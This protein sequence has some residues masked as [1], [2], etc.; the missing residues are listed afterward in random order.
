MTSLIETEE[1][2]DNSSE[3]SDNCDYQNAIKIF[4]DVT[5]PIQQYENLINDI[6]VLNKKLPKINIEKQKEM[7]KIEKYIT[8]FLNHMLLVYLMML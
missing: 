5:L 3:L 6:N 2:K 1:V 7:D 8:Q 4:E